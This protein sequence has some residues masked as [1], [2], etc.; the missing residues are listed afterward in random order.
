VSHA[1][2][3]SGQPNALLTF[4]DLVAPQEQPRYTSSSFFFVVAPEMLNDDLSVT[5]SVRGAELL[6]LNRMFCLCIAN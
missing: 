2:S 5:V 4:I 3:S 1:G 6:Y